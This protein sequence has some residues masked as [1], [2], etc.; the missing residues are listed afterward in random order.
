MVPSARKVRFT[1]SFAICLQSKCANN[2]VY[3]VEYFLPPNTMY[4]RDTKTN[5][6]IILSTM[7]EQL[8]GVI[9]APGKE[10]G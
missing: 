10:L 2:S 7:K 8:P 9:V 1:R 3:V 4:A 5:I 6:N